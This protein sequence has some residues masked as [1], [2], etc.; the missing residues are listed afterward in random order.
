M[1]GLR[2]RTAGMCRG[3]DVVTLGLAG[4]VLSGFAPTFIV[5][6]ASDVYHVA[7]RERGG[8]GFQDRHGAGARVAG[9]CTVSA[10]GGAL[11]Y[12]NYDDVSC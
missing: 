3:R 4:R 7:Q 9:S 6:C 12:D 10:E 1:D 2:A 5:S 8:R 11:Y